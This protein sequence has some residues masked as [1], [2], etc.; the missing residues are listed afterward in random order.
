MTKKIIIP[1]IICLLVLLAA[2]GALQWKSSN[3]DQDIKAE[4]NVTSNATTIE[5]SAIA[6]NTE[7]SATLKTEK[8]EW[9]ATA[10][11]GSLTI[12]AENAPVTITEFSSLS[13]PHCASFHSGALPDLKKDYVDSGK[14]KFVFRDF[15]LNA[16]AVAGSLL[17]KCVPVNDR[18]DFMMMLFEQQAQWAFDPSYAQKLQ[19]YA[20][21][22]GIGSDKAKSCM[23]DK[24]AELAMFDQMRLGNARYGIESTPTFVFEPSE[25]K[26]TGAMPY[27]EFSKRIEKLLIE[28]RE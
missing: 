2:I 15:P 28:A 10:N 9:K 24:D 13:C 21:L 5:T 27:G 8:V 20:A 1:V 23:T 17:L 14:V 6:I 25:E 7:T 12:G 18:Y 4:T 3:A 16:P 22:I 11:A 26:L 19:Q